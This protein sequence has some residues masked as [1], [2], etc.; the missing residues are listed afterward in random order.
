MLK[1][2]IAASF[3]AVFVA[4][5]ASTPQS[6]GQ[7]A[8]ADCKVQ[9]IATASIGA[10]SRESSSL[11]QRYAEMQLATSDYRQRQLHSGLGQTGTVEEALRDCNR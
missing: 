5:C 9:P 7:L 2:A 1:T 10:R 6:A 8:A 4:A 11:D 3:A